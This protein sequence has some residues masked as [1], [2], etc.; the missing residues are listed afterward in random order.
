MTGMPFPGCVPEL[1]D[2]VVRLRAHRPGDAERIVE[3]STDPESRRWTTVPRPYGLADAR[4]FLARI[5]QE[6][7]GPG[8]MRYW[9][10][11]DADDEQGRYLGTIDLRPKG[12]GVAEVGF[13]LH[14]AG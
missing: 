1:T 2:G 10:V 13:G 8:G 12:G 6:W 11:T 5:E 9:A 3:Q 4:E 7:S 14:P